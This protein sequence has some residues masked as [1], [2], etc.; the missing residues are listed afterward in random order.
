MK[1]TNYDHYSPRRQNNLQR[2]EALAER[3]DPFLLALDRHHA[4]LAPPDPAT[5]AS[6]LG[7]AEGSPWAVANLLRRWVF[8]AARLWGHPDSALF[9]RMDWLEGLEA[10]IDGAVERMDTAGHWVAPG[11]ADPNANRFTLTGLLSALVDLHGQPAGAGL[12]DRHAA[13]LA[14][15]VDF[16]REAYRPE[17]ALHQ[18]DYGAGFTPRYPNMDLTFIAILG[19]GAKLLNRPDWAQEAHETMA[20]VQAN[21]LPGGGIHYLKETTEAPDYHRINTTQL[22]RYLEVSGDPEAAL[23]LRRLADYLPTVLTADGVAEHWSGPSWKQD[24]MRAM[25]LPELDPYA[26]G[27]LAVSIHHAPESERP[28][29]LRLFGAALSRIDPEAASPSFA[30]LLPGLEWQAWGMGLW[31]FGASADLAPPE[32]SLGYD[33]NCLGVRGQSG[34]W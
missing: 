5:V 21:V 8:S 7:T 1:F 6:I 16:Q 13:K 30:E 20:R 4:A 28:P 23:F 29:L 27:A 22:R 19:M 32:A 31:P 12:I 26:A 10:L 25:A 24:W 2:W 3:G 14:A 33:N 11:E 34:G 17:S 18:K 9:G 15:A